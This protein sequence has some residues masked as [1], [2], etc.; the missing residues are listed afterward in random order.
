M[1]INKPNENQFEYFGTTPLPETVAVAMAYVPFQTNTAQFAPER[2]LEKGT[3]FVDLNK[4]FLEGKC[5]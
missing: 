1:N 2:A 4:P 3:L 5:R